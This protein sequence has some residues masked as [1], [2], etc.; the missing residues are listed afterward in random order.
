MKSEIDE[1]QPEIDG[2]QPK[3]SKKITHKPWMR[4][5]N[6]RR[7][8]WD[9]SNI[10]DNTNNVIKAHKKKFYTE[11]EIK[12]FWERQVNE[13]DKIIILNEKRL[14]FRGMNLDFYNS[15]KGLLKPKCLDCDTSIKYHIREGNVP[16]AIVHKDCEVPELGTGTNYLSWSDNYRICVKYALTAFDFKTQTKYAPEIGV[17]L[18]TDTV[19]K[20][21]YNWFY[22]AG[23]PLWAE[24]VSTNEEIELDNA[25]KKPMIMLADW[26]SHD[27]EYLLKTE[28][29]VRLDDPSFRYIYI[30]STLIP[31]GYQSETVGLPRLRTSDISKIRKNDGFIYKFYNPEFKG[32]FGLTFYDK[33]SDAQQCKSTEKFIA[34]LPAPVQNTLDERSSIISSKGYNPDSSENEL[35]FQGFQG[36]SKRTRKRKTR[37]KKTRRKKTR[38]S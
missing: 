30:K 24:S 16:S 1:P 31:I 33:L 8:D 14:V 21:D 9:H 17:L 7:I 2:P 5:H 32:I 13:I 28:K 25:Y 20:E 34:G 23:N 11:D 26:S 4:D 29:P 10:T 3:T 18:L 37:R 19:N 36:F 27:G 38:R 12:M 6:C 35:E 15:L 22:P